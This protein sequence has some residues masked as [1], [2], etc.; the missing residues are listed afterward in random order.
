MT[1]QYYLLI[2]FVQG[3][4]PVIIRPQPGAI[5][6]TNEEEKKEE[7]KADF[8]RRLEQASLKTKQN[9]DRVVLCKENNNLVQYICQVYTE[10]T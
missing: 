3:G 8:L 1:A 6:E 5:T 9:I 4:P 7:F 10:L 2:T